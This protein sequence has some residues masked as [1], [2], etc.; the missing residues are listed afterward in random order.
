MSDHAFWLWWTCLVCGFL[1]AFLPVEFYAISIHKAKT[2]T[3]SAWVWKLIGTRS[4][5]HWW[6]TPLRLGVLAL[7]L[8]LAE[9]FAFGWA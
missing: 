8:W 5:W 1:L 4:G 7:F 6:N 9:H 3:L 2:D